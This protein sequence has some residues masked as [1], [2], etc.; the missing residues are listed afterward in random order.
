MSK[1]TDGTTGTDAT[2]DGRVPIAGLDTG[3]ADPPGAPRGDPPLPTDG[4]RFDAAVSAAVDRQMATQMAT[5]S[6]GREK[7]LT[8]SYLQSFID[9]TP[10][11]TVPDLEFKSAVQDLVLAVHQGGGDKPIDWYRGRG[12]ELAKAKFDAL[13]AAGGDGSGDAPE[14]RRPTNEDHGYFSMPNFLGGL[15]KDIEAQGA[16]FSLETLGKGQGNSELEYLAGL[17]DDLK[18]FAH[19]QAGK[20]RALARRSNPNAEVIPFPVGAIQAAVR[21][22]SRFAETYAES[23]TSGAE[24][25]EPTMRGD[26]LVPFFRPNRQLEF[27]GVPMPTISNDVTLPR[28]SSAMSAQWRTETQAI[29]DANLT[30][31]SGT[32]EPHRLGSRDDIS[33]MNLVAAQ[34]SIAITPLA[35]MEMAAACAQAE[36]QAVYG[37]SS[38]NAARPGGIR[39]VTGV[40][41]VTITSDT[42]TY[43]NLLACPD[44]L[45]AANIPEENGRFVITSGIRRDLSTRL[46]FGTLMAGGNRALYEKF[47]VP[48][49]VGG[50]VGGT[51]GY[52]IDYPAG[53]TNNLPDNLTSNTDEHLGIFGAWM[54]MI[55]FHYGMA[56]LT[57]DDVS[58]AASGQTRITLNKFSRHVPAPAGRV[59]DLPVRPVST[60]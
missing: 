33:W 36:E 14:L 32:T 30:I 51:M 38:T 37:P 6:A 15:A 10:G 16:R 19:D 34:E 27:L 55:L 43:D 58:Q 9:G 57:I 13:I 50:A 47:P 23:V 48:G 52:V 46:R 2:M 22:D 29:T 21:A 60:D 28:L 7:E 49:P 25:R 12:A 24:R 3:P 4:P 44:A 26:L 40:G 11:K 39:G 17:P 8:L 59:R 41:T 31:V 1:Q 45:A 53:V 42:P 35:V 20:L 56:F 54:Y 5:M 18:R